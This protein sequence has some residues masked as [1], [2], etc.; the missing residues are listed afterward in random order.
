M[1]FYRKNDQSFRSSASTCLLFTACPILRKCSP[2]LWTSLLQIA[3]KPESK[4]IRQFAPSTVTSK[5]NYMGS[6]KKSRYQMIEK[7]DN[8]YRKVKRYRTSFEGF[9]C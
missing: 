5:V 4:S 1:E 8:D 3:K 9:S 2:E 6:K 7:K